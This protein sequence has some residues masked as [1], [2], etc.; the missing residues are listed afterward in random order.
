MDMP[1]DPIRFRANVYFDGAAAWSEHDWINSEITLGRYSFLR[2]PHRP[3]PPPH[4]RRPIQVEKRMMCRP[5]FGR[6][7]GP[8]V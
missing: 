8:D 1:I 3:A 5:D 7:P 6:Q 4:R 2:A